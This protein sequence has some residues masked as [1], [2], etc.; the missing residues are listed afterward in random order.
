MTVTDQIEAP[1]ED[2][3]IVITRV[4]DAPASVVFEA[5]ANP[6]HVKKWFGP[7]GWPLTLCEM[8]FRVGGRFRFAMTGP[9][10]KQ[11]TPFGGE[12]LEIVPNRKIVFDNGFELPGAERMIVTYTY[13]EVDGK[14]TFTIHTL[15]SSV[16]AKNKHV[17]AG[18]EIG[19]NS[20]I[21]Q[22]EEVANQMNAE[23][24]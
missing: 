3:E 24:R 17:G 12:Y 16:E 4:I 8:D 11:N 7:K 19:Y 6:E 18:F 21:D 13:D 2:R 20:A 22:L 10:G 14:T 23:V 5:Y 1:I 9:S 15:F